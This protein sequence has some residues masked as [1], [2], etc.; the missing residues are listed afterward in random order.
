M[1]QL[2]YTGAPAFDAT[3]QATLDNIALSTNVNWADVST[4]HYS[5]ASNPNGATITL[6]SPVGGLRLSSSTFTAGAGNAITLKML[7]QSL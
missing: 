7:Q 5:S 2:T 4:T 3:I 1:I 6:L